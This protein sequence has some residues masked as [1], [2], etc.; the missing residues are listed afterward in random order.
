MGGRGSSEEGTQANR[1]WPTW[2]SLSGDAKERAETSDSSLHQQLPI[3]LCFLD[4][5]VEDKGAL[6]FSSQ[7]A[8][9]QLNPSIVPGKKSIAGFLQT[10]ATSHLTQQQR[11]RRRE[12]WFEEK[13]DYLEVYQELFL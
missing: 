3:T 7:G 4:L 9:P 10:A 1:A 8:E 6:L 11:R 13:D 2:S 5:T 12:R